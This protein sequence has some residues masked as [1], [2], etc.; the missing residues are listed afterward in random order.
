MSNSTVDRRMIEIYH[1]YKGSNK[2]N[3]VKFQNKSK[4]V[5]G[6]YIRMGL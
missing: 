1:S 2:S 5:T 4:T 3:S 6:A